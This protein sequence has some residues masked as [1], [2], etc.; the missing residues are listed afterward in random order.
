MA[1]LSGIAD[2]SGADDEVTIRDGDMIAGRCR[3]GSIGD[4]V[5]CLVLRIRCS[6]K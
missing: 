5:L 6:L 3:R 1:L 4:L 2:G